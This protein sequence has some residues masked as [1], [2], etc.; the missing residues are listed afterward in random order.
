MGCVERVELETKV[1]KKKT[2]KQTQDVESPSFPV[3]TEKNARIQ[4]F[5]TFIHLHPF[6]FY[7]LNNPLRADLDKLRAVGQIWPAAYSNPAK[8]LFKVQ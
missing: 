1:Q 6:I 4:I 8:H 2:Q 3:G 7:H 5:I